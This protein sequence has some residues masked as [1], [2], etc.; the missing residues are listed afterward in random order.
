MTLR[1]ISIGVFFLAALATVLLLGWPNRVTAWL[2][3]FSIG[4]G[5]SVVLVWMAFLILGGGSR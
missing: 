3:G 5:L 4:L 2:H 1:A